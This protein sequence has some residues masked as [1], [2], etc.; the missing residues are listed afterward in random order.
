MS[1]I[2]ISVYSDEQDEQT[3]LRGRKVISGLIQDLVKLGMRIEHIGSQDKAI[4]LLTSATLVTP[5]ERRAT[6][7]KVEAIESAPKQ[8]SLFKK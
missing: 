5:P 8:Q 2:V 7:R 6:A 3:L 1:K 4:G